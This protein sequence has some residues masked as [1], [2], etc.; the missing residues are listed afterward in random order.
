MSGLLGAVPLSCSSHRFC[1]GQ[2][3]PVVRDDEAR[4]L[5]ADEVRPV[6]VVE[7]RDV[8]L[9]SLTE[10]LTMVTRFDAHLPALLAQPIAVRRVLG[11][12]SVTPLWCLSRVRGC[13]LTV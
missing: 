2:A 9:P 11:P 3:G 8:E 13:S 5:H 4:V 10:P 1:F 12:S 7:R 6:G